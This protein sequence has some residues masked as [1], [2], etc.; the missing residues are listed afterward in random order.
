M[1]DDFWLGVLLAAIIGGSAFYFRV[2][3]YKP[4]SASEYKKK[5][6]EEHNKKK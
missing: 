1:Y 2:F 4:F 5:A 3:K 6:Q